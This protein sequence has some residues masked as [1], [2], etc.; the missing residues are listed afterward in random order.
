MVGQ[1]AAD[2]RAIKPPSPYKG[3]GIRY[4]GEKV[5]LKEGKKLAA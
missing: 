1:V 3:V 2:I 4:S 5:R